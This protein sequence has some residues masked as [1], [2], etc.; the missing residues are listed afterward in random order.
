MFM[1]DIM[2]MGKGNP[3]AMQNGFGDEDDDLAAAIAASLADLKQN[4]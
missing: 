2:D 3:F 1:P 4:G